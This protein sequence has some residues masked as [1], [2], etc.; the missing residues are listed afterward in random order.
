M[1]KNDL[2]ATIPEKLYVTKQYR[3]E[4]ANDTIERTVLGFMS[5]FENTAG[6]RKRRSTQLDWAYVTTYAHAFDP[7]KKWEWGRGQE[8]KLILVT[9]AGEDS[10]IPTRYFA[11]VEQT[12]EPSFPNP[13]A[14]WE[15][16]HP[17]LYPRKLQDVT[18]TQHE[19]IEQVI[20]NVP[21]EGF[22]F[23]R[24]VRRMYWGGGNVVWRVKDPRG[25]E[26]EISSA[27][28][29]RI[30]DCSSIK[31]GMI[32]DACVW[33]RAGAQN[34]LL[35]VS[36]DIYKTANVRT[37]RTKEKLSLKDIN[38]GDIVKL[39]DDEA[40]YVYAGYNHLIY[41]TT[42]IR[43]GKI[44]F[45]NAFKQRY[46][47]IDLSTNEVKVLSSSPKIYELVAKSQVVRTKA[48]MCHLLN[49]ALADRKF[50]DSHLIG[51]VPTKP[52]DIELFLKSTDKVIS[53]Y[54]DC[55]QL[56]EYDWSDRAAYFSKEGYLIC[57]IGNG[58]G[59]SIE[60]PCKLHGTLNLEAKVFTIDCRIEA[61]DSWRHNE[62]KKVTFNF[63]DVTTEPLT[64]VQELWAKLG[65][66][67]LK[68]NNFTTRY[69]N[70]SVY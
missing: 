36:S 25:F 57:R 41:N 9:G 15:K 60:T 22:E 16:N 58:R 50:S 55:D 27:N 30:I 61:C 31:D 67:E 18:D 35:P 14:R 1:A 13:N 5:P 43:I 21:L 6:F 54:A 51:F 46:C 2:G 24:E 37:V 28:L 23:S 17:T 8:N 42:D 38:F 11:W 39:V 48:D 47:F 32:T 10:D 66:F 52:S 12:D 53:S 34:V 26:L 59:Y 49:G 70:G 7:N 44:E 63:T 3:V 19:L 33:G 29:A 20:D 68:V 64:D 56:F 4:H 62:W 40:S 65:E 45:A 69:S